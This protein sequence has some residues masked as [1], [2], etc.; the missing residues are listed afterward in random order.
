MKENLTNM[1][2]LKIDGQGTVSFLSQSYGSDDAVKAW[3][4]CLYEAQCWEAFFFF[5]VGIVSCVIARF[6]VLLK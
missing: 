1:D 4:D 2:P 5:F 6:S 3:F